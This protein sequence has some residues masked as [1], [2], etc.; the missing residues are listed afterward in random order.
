M[1][2]LPLCVGKLDLAFD[3]FLYIKYIYARICIVV[4]EVFITPYEMTVLFLQKGLLLISFPEGHI[5]RD[6]HLLPGL[7]CWPRVCP[8][9]KMVFKHKPLTWP[10]LCSLASHCFCIKAFI[11]PNYLTAS[12]QPLPELDYSFLPVACPHPL[13]APDHSSA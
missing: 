7:R 9:T 4:T 10:W 2:E 12:P 6:Q 11:H 3:I 1:K 13:P 5:T 8:L